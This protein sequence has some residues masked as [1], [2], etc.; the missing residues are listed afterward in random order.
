MSQGTDSGL[1]QLL[2]WHMEPM[3]FLGGDNDEGN[4]KFSHGR[5]ISQTCSWGVTN[6]H[7]VLLVG[8]DLGENGGG[9]A[10]KVPLRQPYCHHLQLSTSMLQCCCFQIYG[11]TYLG[12]TATK[13]PNFR[14]C[15][16]N[17]LKYF[18]KVVV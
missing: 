4:V 8:L 12:H 1:T 15:Q 9:K 14:T 7:V 11:V 17:S 3:V 6:V 18:C 10:R 2:Y 13:E 5:K 16:M